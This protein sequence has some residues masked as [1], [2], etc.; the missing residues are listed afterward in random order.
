M[1]LK[2]EIRA[3]CRKFLALNFKYLFIYFFSQNKSDD[4][5]ICLKPGFCFTMTP[6]ATKA[7]KKAFANVTGIPLYL[8]RPGDLQ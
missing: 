2:L 8:H 3:V 5:L 7:W 4:H 1:Y 6:D